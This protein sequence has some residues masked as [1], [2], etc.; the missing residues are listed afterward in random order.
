P[1]QSLMLLLDLSSF[2]LLRFYAFNVPLQ[3]ELLI[4]S[5]T[6]ILVYIIGSNSGIKLFKIKD[7]KKLFPWISLAIS[8]IMLSFVGWPLA[9]ALALAL[10][11]FLYR[12]RSEEHT[13][14]LQ[15]R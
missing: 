11:G 1:Y 2:I 8:I 6:A 12:R 7:A 14:E 10:L 4:A 5:G 3:P 9:I 13:S 15:S